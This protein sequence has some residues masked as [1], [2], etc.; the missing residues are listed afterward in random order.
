MAVVRLIAAGACVAALAACTTGGA[1]AAPSVQ[2][3]AGFTPERLGRTTTVSLS[4]QITPHGE[5]VPPPL[6]QADL[7]YPAGL[8]V[9]LSGLG[10][11]ACS[12]ATLELSGPEGCPPNSLMGRGYAVA[13]LPIKHA[14]FREAAKIAILRTAE[15]DG[16]FALLLYIYGE[17]AVNAQIVLPA[18]LLPAGGPFGGLL[19]IQVPLVP[20]LPETP[21]VSV[22]EIALVLGP[23]DLTYYERV[24][25]KLIAYRPAGVGLPKRCPRGGFR[26]AIELGFL[27]GAHASATTAVPCPRRSR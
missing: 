21:D 2:L 27:G 11:D 1:A 3:R 25:H 23:K 26:F 16:H 6:T 20:S 10:I 7:R 14:A 5:T 15:Q 19:A 8:D 13:E 9:Q 18:Q 4:I 22:G 12:V 17:T 24:H